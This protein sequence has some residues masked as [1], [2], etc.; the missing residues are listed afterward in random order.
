MLKE[1]FE[2][3]ENS[4][5]NTQRIGEIQQVVHEFMNKEKIERVF[6]EL[7]YLTLSVKT[8]NVYNW[9]IVRKVLEPL[10]LWQGLFKI[11]QSKIEKL[12]ATLPHPAQ[13]KIKS[14]V[15]ETK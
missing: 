11:D 5:K 15:L 6:G 7:G 1:Y 4:Q 12:I 13:E 14:A 3:K 9:E 8:A 10:G 2:L